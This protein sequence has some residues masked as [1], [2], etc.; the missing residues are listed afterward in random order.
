MLLNLKRILRGAVFC[1]LL[2]AMILSLEK[3][4]MLTDE[5]YLSRRYFRY[6]DD[7]FDVIFLGSS[8]SMF[9]IQPMEL[10]E[11]YGIASY[12]LCSGNQPLESSYYLAREVISK[13]HPSLLVLDIGRVFAYD[14]SPSPE[15]IH[16]ISDSMPRFSLNRLRIIT[17]LSEKENRTQLLF[18]L[19]IYHSRWEELAEQDF[20]PQ[21][22]ESLYGAR[23]SGYRKV[24]KG[25]QEP[26]YI[27]NMIKDPA[28]ETLERIISLCKETGTPLLL[29]SMPVPADNEYFD[30]TG[31]NKRWSASRD[32]A[33][34]AE[35]EGV[36]YLG[37][38]GREKEIGIDV[39]R[40][41]FDGEHLNRWGAE[42]ISDLIGSYLTEHYSLPD[43]RGTGGIYAQIDEDAAKYPVTRM[44][45][46][47]HSAPSLRHVANNLT[48]DV[49]EFP[50][51]DV[52][53][54]MALGS[55]IDS[56]CLDEKSGERLKGIGIDAN[57]H[58]WDRHGWI[59]VIDEGSVVYE[60]QKG[61]G[62]SADK[63]EGSS[64]V[65]N[66]RISSGKVSEKEQTV[67]NGISITVN[68]Q[69]YALSGGGLQI[70]VFNKT[71]GELLDVCRIDTK[72]SSLSCTHKDP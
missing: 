33:A 54:L 15:F 18:P 44:K 21:V 27:E 10:Y 32:I 8:L 53:V 64:G 70:A 58:D 13:D 59:A 66:Y 5:E 28:L 68:E 22:K 71:T 6:P 4:T 35:K 30:Q 34:L 72:S 7:T 42:K 67:E 9:G 26:D 39:E 65:L 20:L 46:C 19:Y 17:A 43:R 11:K 12:N 69:E 63:V 60:T 49:R 56:G 41:V 50:V 24:S 2:A 62:D 55:K 3:A 14:P 16:Y 57:L 51:Q 29:L 48:R 45:E 37:Y 38:I 47:L 61:D 31:F 23:I 40:D 52:L 25:F 1:V 36:P